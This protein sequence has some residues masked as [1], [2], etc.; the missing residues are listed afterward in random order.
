MPL[1][2]R[3][4]LLEVAVDVGAVR[5]GACAVFVIDLFAPGGNIFRHSIN[6]NDK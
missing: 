6:Y 4:V 2:V 3:A 5:I 1:D